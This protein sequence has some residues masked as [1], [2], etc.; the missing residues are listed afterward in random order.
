MTDAT[1]RYKAIILSD[2][3][4]IIMK[5]TVYIHIF[6]INM[7]RL[8]Q[9]HQTVGEVDGSKV[10]KI[11]QVSSNEL[12]GGSS[13]STIKI[14]DAEVRVKLITNLLR[15]LALISVSDWPREKSHSST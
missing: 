15:Q 12:W 6:I 2:T 7:N 13:D 10:N 4:L 9:T 14:W 5:L 11:V 3:A 8:L 1:L